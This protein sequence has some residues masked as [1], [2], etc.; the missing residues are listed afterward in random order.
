VRGVDPGNYVA[1]HAM[2]RRVRHGDERK[3]T[4]RRNFH[5]LEEIDQIGGQM[6]PERYECRPELDYPDNM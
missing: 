4:I 6:M 1:V 5:R 3:Q 2:D